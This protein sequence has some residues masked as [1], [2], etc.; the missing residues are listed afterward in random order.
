[1]ARGILVSYGGYPYTTSSLMPDNGLANLLGSLF[2]SG[3]SGIAMDYGTV[4]TIRR[5][6]PAEISGQLKEL[7]RQFGNLSK[8]NSQEALNK[9]QAIVS[10][11]RTVGAATVPEIAE[12]LDIAQ[13]VVRT[14]MN[15]HKDYF[16]RV[17]ESW[18]LLD[19]RTEP[20]SNQSEPSV[21]YHTEPVRPPLGAPFGG[22][23]DEKR[24]EGEVEDGDP[25]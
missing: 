20:P 14:Q 22:S 7:Y 13:T 6:V 10:H 3:H 24:E 8:D 16:V 25:F 1:M 5:L 9:K 23:F 11:L 12:A 18:A 19:D 15:R 2:Q 17:G 4:D 21:S